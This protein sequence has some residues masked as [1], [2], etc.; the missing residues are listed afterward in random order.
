[1][2]SSSS[3]REFLAAASAMGALFSP[4]FGVQSGS[5]TKPRNK[6]GIRTGMLPPGMS[7]AERFQ[8]ARECGFNQLEPPATFDQQEAAQIKEAA[9]AAQ[10]EIGSVSNSM[11]WKYPLTDPNPAVAQ[12]GLEAQTAALENAHFW[13]AEAILM[14]PGIVTPAVSYRDAWIRS[15]QQIAR[16]L[17]LAE[18]LGVYIALEEVAEQARFLLTPVEFAAYIDGFQSRWVRAYFDVG[19]IMPLAYPQ[20]WIHTLGPRIVKVHLKDYNPKTHEFVNLGDGVV[21]WAAVRKAFRD[22][23]YEGTFT[24]ELAGGDKAYLRDVSQ[25]IDRLLSAES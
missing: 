25:R 4:A 22:I 1:M 19:N 21:D 20:D 14:I 6:K 3:R 13:G 15:R 11:N 17:P 2:K 24:V 5:A 10:M 7:H 12:E 16:L 9:T 23:G 8:L 18:K